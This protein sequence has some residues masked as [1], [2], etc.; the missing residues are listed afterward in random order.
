MFP[1]NT[2]LAAAR[3]ISTFFYCS[4]SCTVRKFKTDQRRKQKMKTG[5][6]IPE[7]VSGSK[8]REV[9]RARSYIGFLNVLSRC[10][11]APAC[12]A[13]SAE[14]DPSPRTRLA[15]MTARAWLALVPPLPARA[16]I[17]SLSHNLLNLIGYRSYGERPP[18]HSRPTV[19]VR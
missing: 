14:E 3:P 1:G 11:L 4:S 6:S 10:G 13:I 16:F 8:R 12:L 7:L 17:S 9:I 5:L 19:C 18:H 2:A 15:A